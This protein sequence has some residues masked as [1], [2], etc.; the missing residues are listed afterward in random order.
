[1]LDVYIT[2]C[3]EPG[4]LALTFDDGP[5]NYT[6][7]VLDVL[8]QQQVKATFFIVGNN[9]GKGQIDDEST[10]WPKV[11]RRMHADGHQ[12]ASHSWTHQ[13][14]SAATEEVRSQQIIYNEMAFR[15]IFGWFPKYIRPP[16]G[17][18]SRVSGCLDYVTKLGYHVI[19]YNIDTQDYQHDSASEI[20]LS[21]NIFSN[22]VSLD[23]KVHNYIAMSHDTHQQTAY[24]FTTFML[25]T[26]KERGY[27]AVTVG[28]CLGD[29]PNNWYVNASRA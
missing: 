12:L 7:H 13:N 14:L 27:R 5:Y 18:C 17:T 21:K 20:Q 9:L 26:L 2:N 3:S 23:A 25:K 29:P 15:N 1:M 28:D 16:Y 6:D 19:N 24:N 8:K 11:L 10:G 22:N 4:T